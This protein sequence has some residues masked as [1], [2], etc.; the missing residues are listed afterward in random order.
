MATGQVYPSAWFCK[1]GFGGTQPQTV[2]HQ[3]VH[4]QWM[5]SEHQMEFN[6]CKRDYMACKAQNLIIWT[7]MEKVTSARFKG[8]PTGWSPYL[9][10]ILGQ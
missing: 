7:F 9:H 1:Q 4:H 8:W 6:S 3:F 5:L 10:R 2:H